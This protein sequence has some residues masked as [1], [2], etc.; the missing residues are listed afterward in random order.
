[1]GICILYK[2]NHNLIHHNTFENWC[3]VYDMCINAYDNGSEGNCWNDYTGTDI[4]GDG[5]GDTPYNIPGGNNIDRYPLM[6]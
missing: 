5:I 1:M 3:N 4:D 2:S 6:C